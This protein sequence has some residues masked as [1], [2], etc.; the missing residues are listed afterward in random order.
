MLSPSHPRECTL[1]TNA[2]IL[3]VIIL[4]VYPIK[5]KDV[6]DEWAKKYRKFS[7]IDFFLQL[8]CFESYH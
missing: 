3:T 6:I 5:M 1:S 7:M 8:I 2:N 4:D